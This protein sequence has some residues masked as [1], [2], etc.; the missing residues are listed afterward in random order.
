MNLSKIN[1]KNIIAVGHC[2]DQLGLLI[3]RGNEIE[4]LEVPAPKAAFEGLKQVADYAEVQQ[5]PPSK[6]T[7]IPLLADNSGVF[8]RL[9]NP[10]AVSSDLAIEST[11]TAVCNPCQPATWEMLSS[12]DL[13][14]DELV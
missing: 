12:V 9:E 8:N 1:L 10:Q 4:Y 13:S 14:F 3:D 6:P 2:Q 11:T 5:I 7:M